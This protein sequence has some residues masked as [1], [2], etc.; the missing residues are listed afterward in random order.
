MLGTPVDL[1]KL[2]N[3]HMWKNGKFIIRYSNIAYLPTLFLNVFKI[4]FL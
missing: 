2:Q 1:K 3:F 4:L